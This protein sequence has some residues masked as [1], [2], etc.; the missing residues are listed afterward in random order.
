MQFVGIKDMNLATLRTMPAS[1]IEEALNPEAR[2]ADRV[3]VMPVKRKRR[4]MKEG[5]HPPNA[6][7]FAIE[8]ANPISRLGVSPFAHH[9]MIPMRRMAT[10]MRAVGVLANSYLGLRVARRA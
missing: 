5:L 1:P 7:R 9:L 4:A 2:D 8:K 3:S 10:I 6:C